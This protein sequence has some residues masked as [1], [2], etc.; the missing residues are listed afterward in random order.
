MSRSLFTLPIP[1]LAM[2]CAV[3]G[4]GQAEGSAVFE[5]A[6]TSQEG[7][8]Q[9]AAAPGNRPDVRKA[10]PT[11][12]QIR[13]PISLSEE[14]DRRPQAVAAGFPYGPSRSR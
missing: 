11:G 7:E 2:A 6:E 1:I 5:D 13:L 10:A 3:T 9:E 12:P 14:Q 4:D 8:P